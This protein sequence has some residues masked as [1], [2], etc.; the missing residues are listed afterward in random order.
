MAAPSNEELSTGIASIPWGSW[1]DGSVRKG[2]AVRYDLWATADHTYQMETDGQT[3]SDT[4]MKLIGPDGSNVIME[5]DDS[6]VK[7]RHSWEWT[8]SQ[9]GHYYVD[10]SGGDQGSADTRGVKGAFDPPGHL[11]TILEWVE[12]GGHLPSL[13]SV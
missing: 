10:V 2:A 6:T 12:L 1:Q 13:P 9:S 4:V 8:A 5:N 7:G 3:L 11:L